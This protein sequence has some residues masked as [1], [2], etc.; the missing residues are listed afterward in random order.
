MFEEYSKIFKVLS[1][2]NRIKI[3]ELLIQGETCGCTLIDKLPIS[4]PT[5]S[6]HLK[7]MSEVRLI[8]SVKDGNR[9]NYTVDKSKL[10]DVSDFIS[11]LKDSQTESCDI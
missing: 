7:K 10:S 5:L 4:Q 6:H 11:K 1:D 9:V 8:S 3:I 2:P